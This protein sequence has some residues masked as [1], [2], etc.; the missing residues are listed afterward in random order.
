MDM[1]ND[2]TRLGEGVCRSQIEDRPPLW[3]HGDAT[4]E[5]NPSNLPGSRL[6]FEGGGPFFLG[7]GGPLG[8]VSK[9]T[10]R[11]TTILG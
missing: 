11:N 1:T 5:K 4:C 9:G 10:N 8:L 6:F 2:E 3:G 7:G